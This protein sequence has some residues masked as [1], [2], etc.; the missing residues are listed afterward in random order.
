MA[1]KAASVPVASRVCYN[2]RG[3]EMILCMR[4]RASVIGRDSC[5][6]L[7]PESAIPSMAPTIIESGR[8]I[9]RE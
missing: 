8:E 2:Q 3:R 6:K 4:A 9:E 1:V 7:L 5:G